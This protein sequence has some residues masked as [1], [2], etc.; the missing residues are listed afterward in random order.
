MPRT[1]SPM[2]SPACADKVN[3]KASPNALAI[4]YEELGRI[5]REKEDY[6]SAE[7]SYEEHGQAGP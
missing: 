2:P 3:G 7:H 1:F 6:A 5:Y 4:L